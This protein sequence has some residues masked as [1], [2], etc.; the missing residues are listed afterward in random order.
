MAQTS[1]LFA[2]SS[3]LEDKNAP[4]PPK[5][6]WYQQL[7]PGAQDRKP[8]NDG[9][10][11]ED[12]SEAA[13][14]VRGRIA[15]LEEELRNLRGGR[16][17]SLIEPLL[18]QLSEG[19]RKRIRLALQETQL[20]DAE[21]T[22]IEAESEALATKAVGELA[23]GLGADLLREAELDDL[24]VIIDLEPQEQAHLRRFNAC[25]KASALKLTDSKARK[26]LWIAYERCKRLIP[27]FTQY[28]PDQCWEIIWKNQHGS[29]PDDRNRALHLDILVQDILGSGK[30]LNQE[31]RAI[32]IDNLL[33]QGRLNEAQAHWDLQ[34]RQE[35]QPNPGQLAQ[36]HGFRGVRLFVARRE[37]G[38]AQEI[39]ETLSRNRDPDTARCFSLLIDG[40]ARTQEEKGIHN[41]WNAYLALRGALG[42]NIQIIDFDQVAMCFI[43]A[44]RTDVAL[45]VFKD[46]V[47]MGRESSCGSGQLYKTSLTLLGLLQSRSASPSEVTRV[48]LNALTTLPRK[49][50]NKFF[51]GS[52]IKKLIGL[53]EISAAVSVVELMYERGVTPDP[54]HVNG[55]IGA[56]LRS[57]QSA[58][59]VKAEQLAWAM[60][61]QRLKAVRERRDSGTGPPLE[62]AAGA[63]LQ[64]P[65]HVQR[66]VPAATIETFS[67]LLLYYERRS[68]P[69]AV[70]ALK[71][72]LDLAKIPPNSYFMNHMLYAELRRGQPQRAW[73]IY[74]EM[75]TSVNPDLETF[76]CLWDCEKAYLDR[77][78]VNPTDEFPG[79]RRLFSDFVQWYTKLGKRNQSTVCQDFSEGLYNQIIRCMCLAKDLEATLVALYGLQKFFGFLPNNETLRLIPMQVA[80]IR[81]EESP[82]ARKRRRSRLSDLAGNKAAIA[83][84]SKVFDLVVDR[85]ME[86]LNHRG[87]KLEKCSI[88][89]QNEEQVHVLAEFLRVIIRRQAQDEQAVNNAAQTAAEEM[90]LRGIELRDT[91]QAL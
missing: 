78:S 40:W 91:S 17:Q 41:A 72:H 85:R 12:A 89:R 25:L 77:L 64:I 36:S 79:P 14:E 61:Q 6:R 13:H 45:A 15:K 59:K 28:L 70:H 19:D 23:G 38:K 52:W 16:T 42:S 43:N 32:I 50:Q 75:M 7:F 49:F 76:A 54:K 18:E 86:A 56:W 88:Q 39:A 62:A 11:D 71:K 87:I 80:R 82:V 4:R 5:I 27:S 33:D 67:L 63:H 8:L 20:T 57:G 29:P 66:I 10:E 65:V 24:A 35:Q 48:S 37:L 60:I 30:E 51:Y 21:S 69:D 74:Q 34:Q 31:Q 90:G 83:N 46:M 44:G 73:Q 26:N 9:K 22:E 3:Q 47:L 58:D 84:I 2:T 68:N 55:I 1:Q 81:L 53:G